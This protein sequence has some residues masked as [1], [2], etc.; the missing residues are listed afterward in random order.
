MK[1]IVAVDK[2]W[3]IGN[4]G[5]LLARIKEDLANFRKI[6]N[7]KVVVYGSRTLATYPGGKILPNRTNIILNWDTDYKVD[8]AIIVHSLDELFEELKKYNTD[9]VFVIGGASVYNQLIPYCDTGYVTKFDKSYEK[10]V[11]ITNL[12]QDENWECVYVSERHESNAETDTEGGLGFY[13]TEY[14]RRK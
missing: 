6:T 5:D 7:N 4:K 12:D 8:G 14:R 10:D 9:D 2:E 3:G 1:F 13:F 11:C